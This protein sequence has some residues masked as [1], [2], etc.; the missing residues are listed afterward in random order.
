VMAS[1]FFIYFV[2]EAEHSS[3]RFEKSL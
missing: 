1:P 2:N 3:V